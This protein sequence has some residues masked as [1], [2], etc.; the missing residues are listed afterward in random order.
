MKMLI[1]AL[2]NFARVRNGGNAQGTLYSSPHRLYCAT[3][4]LTGSTTPDVF[5]T[6]GRSSPPG[7]AP[8]AAEMTVQIPEQN[9]GI[10]TNTKRGLLVFLS[11]R[12]S[13][14]QLLNY[15]L[16]SLKRPASDSKK[17]SLVGHV[18]LVKGKPGHS[19]LRI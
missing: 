19:V 18:K 17:S 10:L 7:V 14:L 8:D 1:A 4:A 5:P 12:L 9:A 6:Q 3:L 16:T 15:A 2:P 11:L 13:Y